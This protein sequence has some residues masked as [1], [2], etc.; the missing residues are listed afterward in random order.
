MDDTYYLYKYHRK[1]ISSNNLLLLLDPLLTLLALLGR[2]LHVGG[3]LGWVAALADGITN[4]LCIIGERM[5][6]LCNSSVS[7]STLCT[8]GKL[9]QFLLNIP[10]PPSPLGLDLAPAYRHP[11][12]FSLQL[13]GSP[14]RL[15]PLVTRPGRE[16]LLL[17]RFC[18]G[19][20]FNMRVRFA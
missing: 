14:L 15:L 6:W 13:L 2:R 8:G 18:T 3:N 4:G 10:T 7:L 19:G 16:G 9:L 12:L 17:P 1:N 5:A 20:R 11:L